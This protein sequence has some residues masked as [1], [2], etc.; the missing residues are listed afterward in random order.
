MFEL[1]CK[2]FLRLISTRVV[3]SSRVQVDD[4]K[5]WDKEGWELEVT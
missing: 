2:D 5:I 3:S 1:M 4:A